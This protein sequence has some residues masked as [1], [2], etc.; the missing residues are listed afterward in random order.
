LFEVFRSPAG[1]E[2]WRYAFAPMTSFEVR[3]HQ[4]RSKN[5]VW[6]APVAPVPTTDVRS[7]YQ[8]RSAV[9]TVDK[10]VDINN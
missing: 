8:F 1:T 7:P 3:V 4:G 5:I 6:E 10:E 9:I 2:E